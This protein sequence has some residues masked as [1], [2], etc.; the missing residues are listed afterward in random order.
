M[1]AAAFPICGGGN[2]EIVE[3]FDPKIKPWVFHGA[4]DKIVSPAYSERMVNKMRN[5]GM[6]VKY[7]VYP[8]TGHNAWDNAFA[9]PDL[10]RWIF[11]QTKN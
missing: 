11:S 10:L 5:K 3:L 1:F 7:T 4:A 8:E 2:P 9:E 6:Q